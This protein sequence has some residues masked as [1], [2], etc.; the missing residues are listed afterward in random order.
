MELLGKCLKLF[1]CL[2]VVPTVYCQSEPPTTENPRD[3]LFVKSTET[4]ENPRD[5][6]FVKSTEFVWRQATNNT[7]FTDEEKLLILQIHNSYRSL[8]QPPA[9]DMRELIWD[10][11][12]EEYAWNH[13]HK[14]T[15]AHS[16][17]TM[18][19]KLNPDY[20]QSWITWTAMGEN[21][22]YVHG[23]M[24]SIE[25]ALWMFWTEG[26]DYD[27]VNQQCAPGQECGH[28]RVI[29]LAHS[30]RVGCAINVCNSFTESKYPTPAVFFSCSFD[31]KYLIY[32]KPYTVGP[33]GLDCTLEAQ[34]YDFQYYRNGLCVSP[35]MFFT[36]VGFDGNTSVVGLP[37][38][39]LTSTSA[40]TTRTTA[41][42]VTSTASTTTISTTV[43]QQDNTSVSWE[44]S[45]IVVTT[46]STDKST[47]TTS[48]ITHS[49]A[50]PKIS[51]VKTPTI[52]DSTVVVTPQ[53]T[54]TTS[55]AFISSTMLTTSAELTTTAN[56]T[57]VTG[58]SATTAVQ[59][60]VA[61]TPTSTKR[62]R[63]VSHSS[64]PRAVLPLS[65][66]M[67]LVFILAI[68]DHIFYLF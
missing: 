58:T 6:L 50:T 15:G 1:L 13:T 37:S 20:P 5:Y 9:T 31:G 10:N 42:T 63:T 4:T 45:E 56:S 30:S 18:I 19:K 46:L 35:R 16:A 24:Y 64:R 14:C 26:K 59:T 12:L 32:Y 39:Y 65:I 2:V 40:A 47:A 61:S 49:T 66:A 36:N 23:T 25:Q 43:T 67:L 21:L 11:D 51:T 7:R 54:E 3:Y 28:Y 53:D 8:V 29:T 38:P 33:R 44:T 34:V 57:A 60:T 52:T 68:F 27:I 55:I 62:S 41:S 22:Y 17:G 48:E